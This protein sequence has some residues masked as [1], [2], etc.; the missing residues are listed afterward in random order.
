M[1]LVTGTYVKSDG[2][3]L[4]AG[5]V[6]KIDAIPSKSAIT[7]DGKTVSTYEQTDEPD[8]VTGAFTFDL[9]PTVDVLDAGFYYWIRGYYLRPNGYTTGEGYT[10]HDI[11]EYKL[12]VPTEGGAIGELVNAPGRPFEAWVVVSLTQPQVELHGTYWL[13]AD[14]DGDPNYG[15]GDLYKVV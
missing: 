6:P 5:T 9:I 8:P 10:R 2:T 1:A 3:P 7:I 4:P 13:N 11:F 12:H 14:P 15:N